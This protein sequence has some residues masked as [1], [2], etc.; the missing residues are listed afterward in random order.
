MSPQPWLTIVTIV[1]DDPEGLSRTLA[2]VRHEDLEGTEHLIIDGSTHAGEVRELAKAFDSHATVVRHPPTGI[3]AAMNEALRAAAGQYVM[4]IN[5]GDEL[6]PGAIRELRSSVDQG[7]VPWA[8]GAVEIVDVHGNVVVTPSWDFATEQ[9]YAFSRGKFPAH[10]GTIARTELLREAGGF[11]AS[12]SVAADYAMFLQL[13]TVAPPRIVNGVVARFHEGGESTIRWAKAL[14]DFHRARRRILAPTGERARRER[15]ETLRGFLAAAAYR[16][17]WP[18]VAALALLCVVVMGLTGVAWGGSV[19][20]TALVVVQAVGGAVWWRLLQR[21]R[22][23]GITEAVGMGVGLGTAAAMLTGLFGAWW[24]ATALALASWFLLRARSAAR[25]PALAPLGRWDLVALAAGLIPGLGA[26]L[27]ALRAYPLTWQ[28]LWQG[29]H[30][31]M[32]FFEALGA[33]VAALGPTSSFFLAGQEIRYHTLVYGWAGQLTEA[34]NAEPFVVLTRVLPLVAVIGLV[35]LAASWTRLLTRVSWAPALAAILMVAGG[36]VGATF[37]GVLNFDSPSQTLSTVWLLALSLLALQLIA[38]GNLFVGAV[39]VA[40]IAI[41]VTGG[42]VSSAAVALAAFVILAFI[43][44]LRREPWRYRALVVVMALMVGV[45]GTYV[46]LL[47][48]SANAGGLGLFTFQ[49]RASSVQ[50]LNPVITPRGIVAGVMLLIIAALPR[51][52]GVAWLAGDRTTR[53]T[54]TTIYGIGL[55]GVG[56]ASI[57]A[58]SGGFNDLWFAVAASAPLAVL[59][60]VGVARAVT[61]LGDDD[62]SRVIL[63]VVVSLGASL[64]VGVIWATG[65]TGI[66]GDGWRWAAPLAGISLGV[67]IGCVAASTRS[68]RQPGAYVAFVIVSLVAMTIPSRA[69]YAAVEPFARDF[70]GGTPYVLFSPQ[71]DFVALIDQDRETGWTDQEAAA[72]A[73]LRENAGLHDLIAT[74]I[75]RSA[76]VPALTR[77]ATLA[78]DLRLQA[79]YGRTEAVGIAQ[80]RETQ[81]W[82][83]IDS[84]SPQTFE[85]LCEA[86]VDWVWVD[87]YKT[88]STDWS[89]Y[90]TPVWTSSDAVI[91]RIESS[92]CTQA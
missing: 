60:S 86:G 29:Y 40:L 89:P 23:I 75:T 72:G 12:Y 74:N 57:A 64:I 36:F 45:V 34:T 1:K 79:P 17:P 51:W 32:P 61:W 22:S 76:L 33:S 85:P 5:A 70:E 50:G 49:D 9:S 28:G 58:L 82:D 24:L 18:L 80:V 84:P 37:G 25:P 59:S 87:P 42:K 16:S 63:V 68:I 53:W 66:I 54:P 71:E 41:A 11:D 31:D 14:S 73:W 81:S 7:R 69:V 78:S 48:G 52:M 67:I 77:R 46:W 91:L 8:F 21:G 15:L 90:A 88:R 62:R 19:A 20:L 13:S 56:I 27:V 6:M 55:I 39:A 47:A 26:V 43:G 83:F 92:L 35:T 44:V 65:T 4:F 3:Y 30:G 2:S 10:Q 38:G